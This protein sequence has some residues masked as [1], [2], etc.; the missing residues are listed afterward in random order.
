MH[1]V[2]SHCPD[3]SQAPSLMRGEELRYDSQWIWSKKRQK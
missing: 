2:W 3:T 1:Q